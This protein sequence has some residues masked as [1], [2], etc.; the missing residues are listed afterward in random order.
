[1]AF[2]VNDIIQT[3][4]E[5]LLLT[6]DGEP[7]SGELA[8]VAEGKLNQAINSL[9]SDGYISLSVGTVDKTAAGRI[10]F[11]KLEAGEIP[12]ANVVNSEPPDSITGVSRKV[13]IRWFRLRPTNPQAMDRQLTYSL[14]TSWNYGIKSET[15][16]SGN[17]RQVGVLELN[18]S[19]PTQL[20]VYVNSQLA[21]YKLGD[22]IYLSSLYYNLVL[23]ALE[24]R[25]V[26]KYKLKS[27]E[28]RVNIDLL[29]AKKAVDTNTANN[30]PLHNGLECG[31]SYLDCYEDLI[32]GVGF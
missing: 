24:E 28:D 26:A 30:R 21:H 7:V 16:P 12:D 9:N 2:A 10:V 23:Y 20:R 11:K 1:M 25:L 3:A 27:Y 14:P 4:C 32:G 15:A 22:M 31:G 17:P 8:A 6:D 29:A 5:D 18:G 13:G 19:S